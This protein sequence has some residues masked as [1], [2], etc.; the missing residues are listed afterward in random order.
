MSENATASSSTS[1][2]QLK[3]PAPQ[4]K[5]ATRRKPK[6]ENW[7]DDFEFAAPA[8]K[9][10]PRH[11]ESR[12]DSLRD[13]GRLSPADSQDGSWGDISPG[14]TRLALPHPG[15]STQQ[16]PIEE[17]PT[18]SVFPRTG[19]GLLPPPD[20]S[21]PRSRSR[22]GSDTIRHKL[23][24]RHPSASFASPPL[25][26]LQPQ[27]QSPIFSRPLPRSDSGERMPP[28]PLPSGLV[29]SKSRSKS[30]SSTIK[31]G[32][33]ADV[34]VSGIPFSPS[35]EQMRGNDGEKKPGFWKRL[36]GMP[37]ERRG[38]YPLQCVSS[39]SADYP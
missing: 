4:P 16:T 28:P 8:R 35:T 24:K 32:S 34:R 30:R 29:R 21:P 14:P 9:A 12:R 3:I 10:K 17:F 2:L 19:A 36:S 13:E 7:D 15:R 38:E 22:S 6:A 26:A 1:N 27:P 37:A 31:G 23:I 25:G 11:V 20:G 33:S 5:R 18:L 39:H